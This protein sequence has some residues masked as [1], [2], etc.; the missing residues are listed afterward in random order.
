MFSF[1]LFVGTI[2][3]KLLKPNF[4]KFVEKVTTG[5]WKNPFEFGGNS[6]HVS[7]GLGLELGM[8]LLSDLSVVITATR[9]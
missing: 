4:T 7:L 8:G 6:D 5:P 9:R 3:Q 2:M 1:C